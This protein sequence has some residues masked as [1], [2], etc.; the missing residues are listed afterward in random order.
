MQ[1]VINELP[2]RRKHSSKPPWSSLDPDEDSD[3]P[4][5]VGDDRP[6]RL[7]FAFAAIEDDAGAQRTRDPSRAVRGMAVHHQDVRCVGPHMFD[8]IADCQSFVQRRDDN[9]DDILAFMFASRVH[10]RPKILSLL[11]NRLPLRAGI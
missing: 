3:L 2:M 9:G 10:E 7:A 11:L 4:V 8:N 5:E 6:D 1:A